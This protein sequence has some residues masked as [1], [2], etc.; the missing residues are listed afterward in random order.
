[1]RPHNHSVSL[2]E[3][4]CRV[5]DSTNAGGALHDCIEHWLHVRRRAADDAEHLSGCGLMLQGF[6]QFC[7]ALLQ[8]FEQPHILDGDHGLRSKRLEKR[9]LFV[10]EGANLRAANCNHTNGNPL[11]KQRGTE[12][13]P[14]TMLCG[15]ASSIIRSDRQEVMNMER[16]M[17]DKRT[18]NYI[19]SINGVVTTDGASSDRPISRD[20]L[21]KTT[22]DL[23]GNRCVSRSANSGSILRH[24]IQHRLDICW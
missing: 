7:V 16:F 12:H 4:E 11:A 20:L 22:F 13:G 8:F 5:I 15:A 2:A 24:H 9:D 10:G 19:I 18:T 6:P 3:S 1:M 23:H 17:V 21:K 14:I